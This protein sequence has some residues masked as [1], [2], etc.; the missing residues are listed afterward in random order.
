MNQDSYT[1]VMNEAV[2]IAERLK[3]SPQYAWL[4]GCID[5]CRACCAIAVVQE[6]AG[7]TQKAEENFQ[8]AV[9]GVDSTLNGVLKVS[10]LCHIA[11]DLQR[12]G[13]F[14]AEQ[15]FDSAMQT[16]QK[17]SNAAQTIA[18]VYAMR[19]DVENARQT[20]LRIKHSDQIDAIFSHQALAI[21]FAEAGKFSDALQE[22]KMVE[23]S[24]DHYASL[25]QTIAAVQAETGHI[26]EAEQTVGAP[27]IHRL[28]SDIAQVNNSSIICVWR[29]SRLEYALLSAWTVE[30]VG[31]NLDDFRYAISGIGRSLWR[32][33]SLMTFAKHLVESNEM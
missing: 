33:K 11:V 12:A 23:N 17:M 20:A 31:S 5:Y 22:A 7:E 1:S 15:I 18:E 30:K 27:F 9:K 24:P 26:Q 14:D 10:A 25:L 2:Y 13:Y 16:A 3:P 4:V 8:A 19:G 29:S 6:M 21:S 28:M 32:V